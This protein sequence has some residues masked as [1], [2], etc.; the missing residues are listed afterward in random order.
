M[1]RRYALLF[2]QTVR[3]AGLQEEIE[4]SREKIRSLIRGGRPYSDPDV[5]RACTE[6]EH[7]QLEYS[8]LDKEHK[9]LTAELESRGGTLISPVPEEED[10]KDALRV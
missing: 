2:K 7:L 9:A 5:I 10:E 4:A 8:L 6:C 1:E 3:L